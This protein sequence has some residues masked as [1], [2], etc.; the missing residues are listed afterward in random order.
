MLAPT[1]VLT[2]ATGLPGKRYYGGNV[3]IDKVMVVIVVVMVVVVMTTMMVMMV[4]MLGLFSSQCAGLIYTVGNLV[5][6]PVLTLERTFFA[7]RKFVPKACS[8]G[9][10]LGC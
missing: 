10:R 4:I 3:V 7:D 1:V 2:I 5:R 6:M 9:L 8:G